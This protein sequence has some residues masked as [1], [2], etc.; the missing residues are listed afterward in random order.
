MYMKSLNNTTFF[1]TN[2]VLPP[3]F[4]LSQAYP[5]M[6]QDLD[7][8]FR[9]NSKLETRQ[10][11]CLALVRTSAIDKIHTKGIDTLHYRSI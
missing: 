11:H 1:V 7:R 8:F 6:I 2:L 5:M 9:I 3:G 4:T 10:V